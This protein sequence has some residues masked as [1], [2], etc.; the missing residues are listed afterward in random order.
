M[1]GSNHIDS[2]KEKEVDMRP[3]SNARTRQLKR[4]LA[5]RQEASG[6]Q[7]EGHGTVC[8]EALALGL[9]GLCSAIDCPE[10]GEQTLA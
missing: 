9:V 1:W 6:M 10:R 4:L 8:L 3:T 5:M 7:E 2:C